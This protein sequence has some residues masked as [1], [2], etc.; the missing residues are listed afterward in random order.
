MDFFG[1]FLPKFAVFALKID[2]EIQYSGQKYS[3]LL[4]NVSVESW[5]KI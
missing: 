4:T 5:K 1:D 3:S 2:L